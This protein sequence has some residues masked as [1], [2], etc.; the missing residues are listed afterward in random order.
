MNKIKPE[1]LFEKKFNNTLNDK[2][3]FENLKN[4]NL[5][6]M[7]RD[8]NNYS[9]KLSL[10]KPFQISNTK[11][12]PQSNYNESARNLKN[13][14]IEN[15]MKRKQDF[16]YDNNSNV[17]H[18]KTYS[19]FNSNL[20]EQYIQE[21]NSNCIFNINDGI[22]YK[23][24][25]G[26]KYF[27]HI[28]NFE[29][30]MIKEVNNNHYQTLINNINEWNNNM[31]DKENYIK[32]YK[33]LNNY[34]ENYFSILL[35]HP[36]GFALT[37]II[38]S[39]GFIDNELIRKISENIILNIKREIKENFNNEFCGCDLMLEINHKFKFIPPFLRNIYS[40]DALCNCKITLLKLSKIFK[41]KINP[42]FCLGMIILKMISGNMKLSSLQFLYSNYEKIENEFQCCLF[43]TLIYIENKYLDKNEF[44][45]KDILNLYPNDLCNFLCLCLSFH[46]VNYK[47]IL[48]NDWLSEN[49]NRKQRIKLSFIELLNI[50]QS[51]FNE[52]LFKSF[53]EFYNNFEIIYKK[54]D[55]KFLQNYK[56][57]LIN[58]KY[59]IVILSKYYDIE[60]EFAISKFINI[61]RY[62]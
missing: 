49:K 50:V 14:T 30:Y 55:C 6:K 19:N 28:P 37:D 4:E 24:K 23:I 56:E 21:H 61:S 58:K 43:H 57:K 17:S 53:E 9:V 33:V 8:D 54:I 31:S 5:L 41:I 10:T 16:Y 26:Y 45:L 3:N 15:S 47:N 46:N 22:T 25:N 42:F 52:N 7:K 35:E 62:N 12:R 51:D 13:H 27:I 1:N 59:E 48:G 2:S 39:I 38:N 40:K 36:L 20:N 29:F 11:T 34:N 32:I 44:L 18:S 60:K